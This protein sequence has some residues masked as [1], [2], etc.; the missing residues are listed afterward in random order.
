MSKLNILVPL[1][2]S[3][4][5]KR[6][7]KKLFAM[8]NKLS[9]PLT[10]LHVFDTERVS[11]R[12]VQEMN[13]AMI[14]ERARSVAKEFLEDQKAIF[15]AEGILVETLFVEGPVRKTLCELADSGA[16][17]FLVIGRHTEGELWNLIF[18]QV[19]NYV[20][21]RVKCPVIIV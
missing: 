21:H 18:G 14:E 13:Y 19:S 17:D 15:L 2:G 5:S 11:F 7:I 9:C 20:I 10:L 3:A 1:D 6:T 12:G 4:N 8:K 16:Y